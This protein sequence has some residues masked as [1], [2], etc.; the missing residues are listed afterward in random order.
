MAALLLLLPLPLEAAAA[1]AMVK[2]VVAVAGDLCSVRGSS[3]GRGEHQLYPCGDPSGLLWNATRVN[4][5]F[6]EKIK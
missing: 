4:T 6:K 2:G 1:A 5:T 3:G